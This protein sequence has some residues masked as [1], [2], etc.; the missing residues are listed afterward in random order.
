M[1][2]AAFLRLFP[3]I[4]D[5]CTTLD[6]VKTSLNYPTGMDLSSETGC[7]F[8]TPV[9]AIGVATLVTLFVWIYAAWSPRVI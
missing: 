8:V 5:V 1:Q 2:V 7:R 6:I 4:G 9:N 3:R